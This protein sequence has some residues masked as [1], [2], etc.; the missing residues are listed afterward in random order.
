MRFLVKKIFYKI[1]FILSFI[2]YFTFY[3]FRNDGA[4]RIIMYHSVSY[5]PQEGKIPYNNVDPLVFESHLKIL[6]D[7]G[8]NVICLGEL[9]ENIMK[10]KTI[11]P[12]T[13]VI[14]FDD[15]F[16]NNFDHAFPL[17][18]K[19]N[20]FATFFIITGNI[21]ESR[22]YKHL[23]MDETAIEFFRSFPESR[24]PMS[25]IE[26][27]EMCDR[28]MEIGSHTVTHRSLGNIDVYEANSEIVESKSNLEKITSKAIDL[29]SYPF[30]SR[31]YGD[32]NEQTESLLVGA[33]YKAACTTDIGK[34]SLSTPIYQLPRI[35]VGYN[36]V[37]YDFLFKISGA[38][39]WVNFFKNFFQKTFKR[40]DKT[41]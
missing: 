33:G 19:Y 38:Y 17:L 7:H 14:T 4:A 35:P 5:F 16:K 15:G 6:K 8:H 2:L 36:D 22:P 30:G 11:K 24:L 40:I 32:F 12:K 27:K 28:G 34:V 41:S 13:I 3:R 20:F 31:T 29:F 25:E 10:D 18:K 26:I 9:I 37:Y 23:L 39:D 21:G 1:Q